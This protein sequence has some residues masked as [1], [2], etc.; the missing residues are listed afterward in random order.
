MLLLCAFIWAAEAI[1]VA[2]VRHEYRQVPVYPKGEGNCQGCGY[3]LAGLPA[4]ALCP[5]CGKSDP[6]APTILTRS[7]TIPA[8]V[9][10]RLATAFSLSLLGLVLFAAVLHVAL[11][12]SYV[13]QFGAQRAGQLGAVIRT[14]GMDLEWQESL[15]PIFACG[16]VAALSGLLS[17]EARWFRPTCWLIAAGWLASVIW[18]FLQT[19]AIYG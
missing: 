10:R 13:L 9:V 4:G 7:G 16:S 1:V 18:L 8:Y 17:P 5:E 2:A 11:R 12:W 15:L 14:R 6:G 3:S 19:W